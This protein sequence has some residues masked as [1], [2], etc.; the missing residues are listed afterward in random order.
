MNHLKEIRTGKGLAQA[1]LAVQAE[2][3]PTVIANIERWGYKPTERVREKIARALGVTLADI[4]PPDPALV[5]TP[6]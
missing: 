3:S 2:V 6:A 1:G 5:A 4:W